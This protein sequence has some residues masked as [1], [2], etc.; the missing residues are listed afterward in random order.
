M[1]TPEAEREV[2]LHVET[3]IRLIRDGCSFTVASRVLWHQPLHPGA[4]DTVASVILMNGYRSTICVRAVLQWVYSGDTLH[5]LLDL[6]AFHDVPVFC[7]LGR[8]YPNHLL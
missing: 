7:R 4:L 5:A 8:S 3:L 2:R 6:F 1:E